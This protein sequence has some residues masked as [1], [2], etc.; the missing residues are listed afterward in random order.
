M[1]GAVKDRG[2]DREYALR[3]LCGS[4]SCEED[5]DLQNRTQ[6]STF[7]MNITWKKYEYCMSAVYF[8]Q[9]ITLRSGFL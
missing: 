6:C 8:N 4:S 7:A 2:L 5:I 9:K 1:T 3:T